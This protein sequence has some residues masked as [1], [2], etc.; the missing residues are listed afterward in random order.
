MK[1][2]TKRAGD[3]GCKHVF[4]AHHD[5]GVTRITYFCGP[6]DR[7]RA[8]ELLADAEGA[9]AHAIRDSP[10]KDGRLR[11]EDLC[12]CGARERGDGH[13]PE[14]GFHDDECEY[15]SVLAAQPEGAL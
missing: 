14:S 6:G 5:Q 2:M 11:P 7:E 1:T 10:H 9:P 4:Y 13:C 3:N 12:T 8:R 15:L